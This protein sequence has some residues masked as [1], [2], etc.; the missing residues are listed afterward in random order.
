MLLRSERHSAFRVHFWPSFGTA[1]AP[2]T[3]DLCLS[4]TRSELTIA[5]QIQLASKYSGSLVRI[6]NKEPESHNMVKN[7]VAPGTNSTRAHSHTP[8]LVAHTLYVRR[9]TP[10]S[11]AHASL[12]RTF[13]PA[14]SMC[15][16]RV[17]P[18][19][20]TISPVA[21]HSLI[22]LTHTVA[23]DRKQPWLGIPRKNRFRIPSIPILLAPTRNQCN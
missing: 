22:S 14:T 18:D 12:S 4:N 9:S 23:N 8:P 1:W 20:A 21:I 5:S 6:K 15:E 17:D 7:F 13:P 2:I 16:T 19:I 3:L 10:R 11:R